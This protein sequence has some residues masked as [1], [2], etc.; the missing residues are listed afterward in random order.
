MDAM[1]LSLSGR[2]PQHVPPKLLPGLARAVGLSIGRS[3]DFDF[4]KDELRRQV[5]KGQKDWSA[6]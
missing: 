3:P 1:K 2:P 6:Q 4:V 5:W